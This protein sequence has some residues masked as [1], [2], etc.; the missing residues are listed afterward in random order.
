MSLVKHKV[1]IMRKLFLLPITI[2]M[3]F[4]AQLGAAQ[5]SGNQTKADE[6]NAQKKWYHPTNE[7]RQL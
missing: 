7:D 4:S 2:L 6:M 3:L 1:S 5:V